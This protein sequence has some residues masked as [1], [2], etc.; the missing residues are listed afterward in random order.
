MLRV[1]VRGSQLALAYAEK[2][3]K[4]LPCETEIVIIKTDG[5]IYTDV[6][7]HS[8]G[9]KAVFCTAI[10]KELLANNIDCAV[11]S[12][13][14]MP[15]E[16][17]PGLVVNAVVERN[18][19]R[20]VLIGKVFNGCVIGTSSPRRKSQ[21]LDLY[22]DMNVTIKDIRGNVD[23][24]LNK[25]DN[26]EYDAIVLA[27]AGLQTLGIN[28]EW[29]ALPIIPAVGQGIIAI[30]TR[31]NDIQTNNIVK[32]VNH[33]LTFAHARVE[34]AFLKG[35]GGDCHTKLAGIA[36]GFNPIRFE[37]VYYE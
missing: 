15:G 6:P 26:S 14:D 21:I 13:K 34:R 1:G 28:R 35:M 36:T 24:R 10:E 11:H 4:L 31:A 20:D 5:D 22:A 9:G 2:V 32:S 29:I 3:C 12:L 33:E 18:S 16:D 27:E 8:I 17:T 23:T 25:L 37:A 19:T 30:Q 7:I